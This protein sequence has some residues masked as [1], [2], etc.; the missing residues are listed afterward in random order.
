MAAAFAY[1]A[2]LPMYVFHCEAGVFGKSRFQD[3]PAIDQFGHVLRLLPPDLP[4]WQRNDGKDTNAVFTVFADGKPNRYWPELDSASDGCVRNTG[5][6]KGDQFV[7]VPIGIRSGGLELQA[8][9]A[10]RFTAFNPLTGEEIKTSTVRSREKIK[11]P[12][13]PGA[14]LL[15]GRILPGEASRKSD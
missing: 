12:P 15:L 14:W 9:R 8:R 4:H 2:K 1:A 5:S 13:G 7:C 6:R 3:T 11:L 10:V